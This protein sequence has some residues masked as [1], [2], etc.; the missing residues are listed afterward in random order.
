[1]FW[2]RQRQSQ[3]VIENYFFIVSANLIQINF[4]KVKQ[5][6]ASTKLCK[7]FHGLYI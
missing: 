5:Q 2:K 6:Y 4:D 7:N 1:M 3:E